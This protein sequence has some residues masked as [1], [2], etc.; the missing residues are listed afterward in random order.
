MMSDHS[1]A[2]I[3]ACATPPG[4]GGVAVIRLSGSQAQDIA[5]TL[6]KKSLPKRIAT[7]VTFFDAAGE[8][9][10]SGLALYFQGP[11]SYTGEDVVELHS[12]GSPTIVE[13]IIQAA[14]HYGAEMA[15]P[16]AFTQRAFLHGKMDLFQAEAV[17][18]LIDAE[19]AM[20]AKAAVRSLQ[21]V[22][23][24]QVHTLVA[25]LT[26]VRVRVE[27]GIDFSEE[28][29]D[30]ESQSL[31]NQQIG[32]LLADMAPLIIRTQQGK[33]LSEGLRVVLAGPTNAGKSTLYNYFTGEEDAIV[34][35]EPGT[36]RDVLR[37]CVRLG[38][39]G[40]VI[41]LLDTAGIRDTEGMVE[42]M[43]IARSKQHVAEADVVLL[44]LSASTYQEGDFERF[45]N[46][47]LNFSGLSGNIC[48]IL[49]QCDTVDT[50]ISR[51]L[52][53]HAM[54]FYISAKTG[55]GV[56]PL[57]DALSA[58]CLG[59]LGASETTF[60]AR[61]R[62][63]EALRRAQSALQLALDNGQGGGAVEI[64]AEHLRIAQDALGQITGEMTSDDLL[65]E[66][67]GAFC[68]GK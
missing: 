48:L 16:G 60:I 53:A 33:K 55:Q 20:A 28:D 23:S 56:A 29:I 61:A 24:E 65:G 32:R 47:S 21:G 67:F 8:A 52:E 45:I 64:G 19:S 37:Q 42:Q 36:T 66:I 4:R 15:G 59:D 13:L 10:D 44:V 9:I 3:I 1:S 11:A 51:E 14:L 39:S 40:V 38:T 12:H 41:E 62:H 57:I 63:V 68:I 5:T 27:A 2:T 50:I 31:I 30:H 35:A 34:T 17:A 54:G 49:N 46:N 22:F 6:V 26:Q 25:A 58:H 18:S 43:G 7:C